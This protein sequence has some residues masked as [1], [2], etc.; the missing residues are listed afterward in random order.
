MATA[1]TGAREYE[2][3]L[4][5][6]YFRMFL[7][8]TPGASEAAGWAAKLAA[9]TRDEALIGQFVASAEYFR[10]AGGTNAGWLNH[11]YTDLLG[12]ARDAGSQ[13]LLDALTHGTSRLQVANA[14]LAGAEYRGRV[15]TALFSRFLGRA[16]SAGDVRM[17]GQ[18]LTSGG[19]DEQLVNA[20]LASA[21]YFQRPH[22]YP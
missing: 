19:T 16:A 12:R 5:I 15:V 8:R 13:P 14:V 1:F 6:Q 9:G 4:V 11:L 17:W 20:L 2:T 22:V 3:A 10:R 18:F 21:E 7:G